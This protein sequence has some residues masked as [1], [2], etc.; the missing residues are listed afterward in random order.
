MKRKDRNYKHI[1]PSPSFKNMENPLLLKALWVRIFLYFG[2][3]SVFSV[4]VGWNDK[5]RKKPKVSRIMYKKACW[6]TDLE[7]VTC[8]HTRQR[9]IVAREIREDYMKRLFEQSMECSG[10]LHRLRWVWISFVWGEYKS[11]T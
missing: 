2:N 9:K 4:F 3:L 1:Y 10:E 5:Q 6:I 8:R 7:K 11:S